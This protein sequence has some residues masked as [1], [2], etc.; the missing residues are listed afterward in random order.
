MQG[1]VLGQDLSQGSQYY[2]LQ[3]REQQALLYNSEIKSQNY[4]VLDPHES[5]SSRSSIL[6]SQLR[7]W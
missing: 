2:V 6:Q 4:G 7:I 5:G 1:L 3:G